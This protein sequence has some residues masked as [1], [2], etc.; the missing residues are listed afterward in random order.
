LEIIQ[1]TADVAHSERYSQRFVTALRDAIETGAVL[2]T[3]EPHD[4][5]PANTYIG[6]EDDTF[7]Y[8]TS[9]GIKLVKMFAQRTG[10]DINIDLTTLRRQLYTDGLTYSTAA[11]IE[12]NR[13]DYQPFQG[14]KLVTA[15]FQDMLW[16]H[17]STGVKG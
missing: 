7:V 1:E 13:Y 11:R 6:W 5:A 9:G 14:S 15:F 17:K 16:P 2:V 8:V 3:P 10:M 4:K 12:A